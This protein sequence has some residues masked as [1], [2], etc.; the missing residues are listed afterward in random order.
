MLPPLGETNI[1]IC[2]PLRPTPGSAQESSVCVKWNFLDGGR[3]E[4]ASD[5]AGSEAAA[6]A[7]SRIAAAAA[8]G[9]TTAFLMGGGPAPSLNFFVRAQ[10]RRPARA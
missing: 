1:A 9:N 6:A 3:A 10:P 5:S 2:V 4:A 8:A 7:A